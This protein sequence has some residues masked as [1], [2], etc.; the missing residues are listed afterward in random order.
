[1]TLSEL[2]QI[3]ESLKECDPDVEYF[4]WGPTYEFA[5]QRKEAALKILRR[6]IKELKCLE[7]MKS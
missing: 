3:M 5:K 4:C 7:Q 1:M 2:K 6:E